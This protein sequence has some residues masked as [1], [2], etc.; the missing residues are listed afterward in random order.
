MTHA[1]EL[2]GLGK[3]YP[4][5]S[6]QDISFTLPWGQVMGVV[7]ENGAGITTP[8]TAMLEII[9]RDAG[10]VRLLGQSLATHEKAV[11]EQIGVVLAEGQFHDTL[12]L[13][14]LHKVLKGIYASWDDGLFETLCKRFSLPKQK[15]FKEFSTGM[16]RKA[17]IVAAMAHHPRLLILDE[18]T[19][20]LDPVVREEMLDLFLEFMQ[21]EDHAIL[22]SS[23]ITGDLDK[24]ADSVTFLHQGRM[25]FSRSREE[26][27]EK[28]GLLQCGAKAF[29]A[30]DKG[31]ML[32]VRK[33]AFD[34]EA[35]VEDRPYYAARYPDLMI[36]PA[37]TE[38]I[39]LFYIRGE[40]L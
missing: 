36:R 24:I 27:S 26:L 34:V 12:A 7:G 40:K 35:L 28:M 37:T 1:I 10:E 20:G 21:A 13:S 11:K 32:R 8:I 3:R 33:S 23:H 29:D 18:P 31:R 17:A 15:V 25:I 19:S 6:L 16:R 9:R 22:L 38:E 2:Q 4:D 5:F 39:M 14:D 30:L